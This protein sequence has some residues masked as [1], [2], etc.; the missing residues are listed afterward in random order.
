MKQ[1]ET[2]KTNTDYRLPT[3]VYPNIR[4]KTFLYFGAL[5]HFKHTYVTYICFLWR[6]CYTFCTK[7]PEVDRKINIYCVYNI[8]WL[9]LFSFWRIISNVSC[10]VARGKSPRGK[11]LLLMDEKYISEVL[12]EW[13]VLLKTIK[14]QSSLLS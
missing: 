9:A 8:Y 2:L 11:I 5:T 1:L 7:Y 4:N 10:I 3:T 13:M 12:T 14:N 6:A